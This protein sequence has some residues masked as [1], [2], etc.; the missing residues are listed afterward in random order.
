MI[1]FEFCLTNFH[2]SLERQ[3]FYE[4]TEVGTEFVLVQSEAEV[5]GRSLRVAER[6]QNL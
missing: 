1:E 5:S 3:I 2:E 6:G 4:N